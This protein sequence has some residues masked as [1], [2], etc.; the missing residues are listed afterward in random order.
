MANCR[1]VLAAC[2]LAAIAL[3]AD[4]AEVR[5]AAEGWTAVTISVSGWGAARAPSLSTATALALKDC[6]SRSHRASDCGAEMKTVRAG[7]IL[8]LRC[9]RYRVLTSGD[10]L[11]DAQE[12]AAHRILQLKYISNIALP[13]CI[14]I[15]QGPAEH[16]DGFDTRPLDQ[17][18]RDHDMRERVQPIL[19]ATR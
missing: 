9:G 11:E 3:Q 6:R 14:R 10:T 1:S 7:W 17:V 4:A 5:S 19:K 2:M 13:R 16:P 15:L 12:D 8:A 18:S